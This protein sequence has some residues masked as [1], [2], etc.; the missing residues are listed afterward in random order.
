[1]RDPTFDRKVASLLTFSPLIIFLSTLPG[2]SGIY[3][4]VLKMDKKIIRGENVSKDAT[5]RSKVGSLMWLCMGIRYD[6]VYVT[7]ELS[8]VLQ[9]PTQTDTVGI[10]RYL[11]VS[12]SL[13]V[14][15]FIDSWIDPFFVLDM[16]NPRKSL[17]VSNLLSKCWLNFSCKYL[18]A[19][20]LP[21]IRASSTYR[22]KK[23]SPSLWSKW[24]RQ[25]SLG[26]CSMPIFI[27]VACV[28]S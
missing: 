5:F 26:H 9:D 3:W 15:V 14:N 10:I 23:H 6:L 25:G 19:V 16:S 21:V 18:T 2:I 4:N 22:S 13:L 1:M 20:G 8:R 7:K 28:W 27:R 17:G 12:V 24:K 11:N